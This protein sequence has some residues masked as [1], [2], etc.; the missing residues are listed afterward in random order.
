M[1]LRYASGLFQAYLL[2]LSLFSPFITKLLKFDYNYDCYL[3]K[4]VLLVIYITNLYHWKISTFIPSEDEILVKKMP[5][6]L[7]EKKTGWRQWTL[8]LIFRVDVHM[9]LDPPPSSTWAWPPPCG[10]HKWMALT[11]MI[12]SCLA[13]TYLHRPLCITVNAR[14]T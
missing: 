3:Y 9:E 7:Q 10:R 6:S 4:T 5:T 13:V 8:I 12:C 11:N 2:F 1:A 14:S